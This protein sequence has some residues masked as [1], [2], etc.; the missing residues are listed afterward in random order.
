M[1][2]QDP[3]T[4]TEAADY[5]LASCEAAD[6]EAIMAHAGKENFP[7][8]SRL[9]P[10][11]LRPHLLTVYGYARLVDQ[12]GDDARGDR[13]RLLAAVA[14]ELDA[15]YE[16]GTPAHPLLQRLAATVRRFDLPRHPFDRLLQANLQD[17]EVTRYDTFDELLQY[18]RLSAQPVGELVLR[19]AEL[20]TPERLAL[21]DDTC[22]GLQLVEFCQDVGEDA[23]RGRIYLPAE[24]MRRFGYAEDDLL[25][26]V[27]DE[28]FVRLMRFEAG[29][30]GEYLERGRGLSRTLPGRLGF[31]IRLYS[32]GGFAALDDLERR[33]YS[34]LGSSAHVSRGRLFCAGLRELVRR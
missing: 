34:T 31:A 8:A 22:V 32:A 6:V 21:S 13:R 29:R 28:R 25:G 15:I 11:D 9:F 20:C 2:T 10:R 4:G 18:C 12:L 26:G 30:A 7:V 16:G 23:G 1:R 19:V 27:A 3:P 5:A 33:G 17:Q 24:D 14:A